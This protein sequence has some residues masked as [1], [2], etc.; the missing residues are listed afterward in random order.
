MRIETCYFCSS[1]I[2]PGHGI[3]FVRNDCKIFR[4]CRSKCHAAFKKKKNPRKVKWTKAYRKTFGK[5][6]VV[7]PS[8]EFEKRRNVP[9]KYNRELWTNA[10]DAIKKVE[11]IRQKRQNLHIMQR[12]RKGRELEQERDIKEVQR[13]LSLVRSPAVGLKERRKL[14]ETAE[15]EEMQDSND[16][17]EQQE[18]EVN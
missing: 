6:L 1:R 13:D 2:Y 5:E 11:T 9:V 10:I 18:M 4:F 8:F 14:E 15:Q 7:D 3:Q 12:L 16:E 17:Q